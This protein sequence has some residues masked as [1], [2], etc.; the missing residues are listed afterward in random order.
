MAVLALGIGVWFWTLDIYSTVSNP[1]SPD[2]LFCGSA[3]DI[4]LLKGDGYMGGE[5]APNQD[6]ID[7]DCMRQGRAAL[8]WAT[9]ATS[10]GAGAAW[11]GLRS[12]RVLHSRRELLHSR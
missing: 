4:V 10:V 12:L 6:A 9:A 11:L 5:Y 1:V 2:Q 7:R 3:Y 8:G